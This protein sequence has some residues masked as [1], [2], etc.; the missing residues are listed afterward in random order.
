MPPRNLYI[1]FILLGINSFSNFKLLRHMNKLY[2]QVNNF[3]N[4][5]EWSQ[6]SIKF[7]ERKTCINLL[8]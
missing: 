3:Q 6:L 1:S 8:T 7:R 4:Y 5:I 2:K